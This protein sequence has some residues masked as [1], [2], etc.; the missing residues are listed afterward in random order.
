MVTKSQSC[1]NPSRNFLF[2]IVLIYIFM[3]SVGLNDIVVF[4][5][6]IRKLIALCFLN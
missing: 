6:D 3:F 4:F 5:I 1:G 2:L